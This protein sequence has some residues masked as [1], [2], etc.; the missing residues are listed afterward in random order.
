MSIEKI[1]EIGYKLGYILGE[2]CVVCLIAIIL[3]LTV[4][5]ISWIF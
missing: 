1:K 5:F 3:A 4:R 2:I